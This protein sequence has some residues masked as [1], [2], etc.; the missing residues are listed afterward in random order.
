MALH[1]AVDVHVLNG[2]PLGFVHVALQGRPLLVRDERQLTD[3]IEWMGAEPMAFSH[4]VEA[5]L[6]DILS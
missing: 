6:R 5:Y 2:A 3:F 1:M 4:H